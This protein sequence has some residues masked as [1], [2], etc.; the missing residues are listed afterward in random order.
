MLFN[1]RRRGKL[2]ELYYGC[3]VK[4]LLSWIFRLFWSSIILR[5][6]FVRLF[7]YSQIQLLLTSL[8]KVWKYDSWLQKL[9]LIFYPLLLRSFLW[10]QL[11]LLFCL[12]IKLIL[13]Q[14]FVMRCIAW[15]TR[16]YWLL[17]LFWFV[18][19]SAERFLFTRGSVFCFK[20]A[21]ILISFVT[22]EFLKFL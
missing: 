10:L 1:R 11:I 6:L 19:F 7:L 17:L 2:F 20:R 14:V 13:K 15:K 8:Q 9:C 3:L 4:S 22:W 21:W 18:L 12:F 5:V 16:N